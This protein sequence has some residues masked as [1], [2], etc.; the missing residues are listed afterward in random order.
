[1]IV[2]KD[3]YYVLMMSGLGNV[4]KCKKLIKERRISVNDKIIDDIK[5]QVDI[6]DS[7]YFDNQKIEQPFV[8]YMLNKPKDYLCANFDNKYMCVS[9]LIQRNDCYCLG[10]LDLDTTGLLILTNDKTLSKRLLLPQNHVEKKYYVTLENKLNNDLIDLFNQG[11]IIDKNIKCQP[12]LLE[13][14]DDYHC[15]LTLQQGRY[16]QVKKM[17]LSCNN[18][19]CAL[20][21]VAF[22]KI[23]LDQQLPLGKYR[24]L[25]KQEIQHLL[26]AAKQKDK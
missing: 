24:S 2:I 12:A 19:V 22:A 17:F 10:R 7:I 8:Y 25:T 14:I 21:R 23:E 20:K 6:D 15:Y 9:E 26:N 4:N 16:H 3:L 18:R 11:I 13:I 5:F 1:M